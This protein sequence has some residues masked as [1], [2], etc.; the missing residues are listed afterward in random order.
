MADADPPKHTCELC[1]APM[2]MVRVAPRIGGLPE[3]QTFLCK[4][5]NHAITEERGDD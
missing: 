1:G 4:E 5:C 2:K 3:L